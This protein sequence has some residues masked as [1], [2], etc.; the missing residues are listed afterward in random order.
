MTAALCDGNDVEAVYEAAY[1]AVARA[2]AGGGP[3]FI[4]CKTYR[5][6][7]HS[8]TDPAK[9]RDPAEVEAW[10]KGDPLILYRVALK[11]RAILGTAEAANIV[12]GPNVGVRRLAEHHAAR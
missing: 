2:R 4:E 9:Y 1:P 11:E 6:R 3:T 10:M 8:C 12:Q 5:H 7:G